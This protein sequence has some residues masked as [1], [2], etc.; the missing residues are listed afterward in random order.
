MSS[1][2]KGRHRW[3]RRYRSTGNRHRR[4]RSDQ[5]RCAYVPKIMYTA[6]GVHLRRATPAWPSLCLEQYPSLIEKFLQKEITFRCRQVGEA[7]LQSTRE[8]APSAAEAV[9]RQNRARGKTVRRIRQITKSGECR[10]TTQTGTTEERD[11]PDRRKKGRDR[12]RTD[13]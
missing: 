3:R 7:C 2:T 9:A 1:K 8:S 4:H 10:E 13:K 12:R 11:R 6:S 5:L